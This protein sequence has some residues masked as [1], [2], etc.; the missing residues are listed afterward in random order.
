MNEDRLSALLRETPIPREAEA[1]RRGLLMAS[2]VFAQ[3][4][5][6]R[7][8]AFPR[9]ALAVGISALL[10]GILLSP[11]GAAVRDWVRN[12]F[13]TGVPDA[14]RALTEVPG[15]G[16]LLVQSQAGPWVVQPD[17]SRRLL[18][19]YGDAT[20]SPHGLF[21]A[22]TAGSTLSALEPDGTPRW[23]ISAASAIADPRWSPSGVRIAYRTGRELRV[24]NADGTEDRAVDPDVAFAP[25]AWVPSGLHLLA[26]VDGKRRLRMVDTDSGELAA[27]ALAIPGTLG[28]A[29]SPDGSLL[30]EWTER[31]LWLRA[32]S[33]DKLSQRIETGPPRRVPLPRNAAVRAA[34]FSPRDRTIAAL[35]RLPARPAG[36]PHSEVIA[37]DPDGGPRRRPFAVSGELSDL[38]WSPDGSRLL[39]S[40]PDADQ[41]LFLSLRRA[42]RIQAVEGI[43]SVFSPGHSGR[44]PFPKIDSWCCATHSSFAP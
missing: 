15:G 24:V 44:A 22:A 10:M 43:A 28:L 33:S 20:W 13:T 37:V 34:A 41:W 35:L 25:P 4:Q 2:E 12:V 26:Y 5:T 18:G 1:E 9:L 6:P 16:R 21:V 11:A 42:G 3:R 17:G 38:T 32:V 27:S 7:R 19:Q 39:V 30:L 40:W 29:W 8:Q 36:G 14:E 31:G 23:S